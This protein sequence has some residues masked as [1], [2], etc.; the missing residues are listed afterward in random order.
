MLKAKHYGSNGQAKGEIDLPEAL[1]GIEPNKSLVWQAVRAYL[2]AQRQGTASTKH[3][4][5]V[6]GGGRKPWKQKGTGRARA[7]TIRAAQWRG[8]YTVFGPK[9]R[10][11]N[12]KLP[13]R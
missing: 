8:G 3:R 11:Y 12:Q 13:K 6:S 9:P 7:G 1:F 5:Q 2:A 10:S 4:S